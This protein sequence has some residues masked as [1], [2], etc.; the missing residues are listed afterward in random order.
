MNYYYLFMGLFIL[1]ISYMELRE[2]QTDTD[3]LEVFDLYAWISISKEENPLAYW[4]LILLQICVGIGL[5]VKGF[6]G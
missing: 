3:A 5:V 1:Y 6:I 4:G 2:K